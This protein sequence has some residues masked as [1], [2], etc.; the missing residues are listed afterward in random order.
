MTKHAEPVVLYT[1]QMEEIKKRIEVI[2]FFLGMKGSAL[3][4]QP[5]VESICLQ[6]R[7]VLELI[8]FASLT[9]NK[10]AYAAVHKDFASHHKVDI[11][12]KELGR[13]NPHFYPVPVSPKPK[14]VDGVFVPEL[15]TAGILTQEDFVDVFKKCGRLL[16]TPNPFGGSPSIVFYEKSFPVWLDK[17][18]RLLNTHEVH[19]VD[20]PSMWVIHM[21][22]DGD[23]RVHYHVF[24][25]LPS[26]G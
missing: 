26:H 9:A 7:K 8:A 12:L 16:H 17:I 5:T 15:I 23:D 2:S 6:F 10:K 24:E 4:V 13:I 19:F 22:E 21:Q 1:R 18:I 20:D 25:R 11:L 14:L 3:Y